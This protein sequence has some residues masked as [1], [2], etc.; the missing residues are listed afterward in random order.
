ML[1]YCVAALAAIEIAPGANSWMFELLLD[2]MDRTCEIP[3]L[4]AS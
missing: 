3:T 4:K 1:L 2:V